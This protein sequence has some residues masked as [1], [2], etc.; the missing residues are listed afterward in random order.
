MA[1]SFV[2][3]AVPSNPPIPVKDGE[4]KEKEIKKS[5]HAKNENMEISGIIPSVPLDIALMHIETDAL[6]DSLRN[7]AVTPKEV[8]QLSP[9]NSTGTD[10]TDGLTFGSTIQQSETA[11]NSNETDGDD[12]IS[13]DSDDGMRG[14]IIKLHKAT[15]EINQSLSNLD[16]QNDDQNSIG[17]MLPQTVEFYDNVTERQQKPSVDGFSMLVTEI[18]M[19]SEEISAF[20][21]KNP[22]LQK[23]LRSKMF[24]TSSQWLKMRPRAVA[25]LYVLLSAFS[26]WLKRKLR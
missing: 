21:I 11:D 6:L 20:F 10:S 26:I 14:E 4:E 23:L 16:A 13:I 5:P 19:I 22:R 18:L 24:Q 25:L 9:T 2:I 8:V 15:T 3:T 1:S 12:S 17:E 7:S